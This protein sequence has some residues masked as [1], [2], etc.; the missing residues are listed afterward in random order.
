M[1]RYE[2]TF[3]G[4]HN[5]SRAVSEIL[6]WTGAAVIMKCRTGKEMMI[7]GKKHMKREWKLQGGDETLRN[8]RK[9]NACGKLQ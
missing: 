4:K 6:V 1:Q 9:K 2:I 8:R 7:C 5:D 3:T